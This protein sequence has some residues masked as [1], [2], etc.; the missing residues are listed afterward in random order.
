MQAQ[1]N[2]MLNEEISN[3]NPT[4]DRL[5]RIKQELTVSL[6]QIHNMHD[7]FRALSN[8]SDT[9]TTAHVDQLTRD[10]D[11]LCDH[12][13]SALNHLSARPK[14]L[15]GKSARNSG[16]SLSS[17]SSRF[18]SIASSAHSSSVRSHGSS[19]L[20]QIKK[21]EA[22][23]RLIE[24]Q[25]KLAANTKTM[26]I[27]KQMAELRQQMT[28]VELE[29]QIEAEKQKAAIYSQAMLDE[30]CSNSGLM[31]QPTQIINH[32]ASPVQVQT[33]PLPIAVE[34]VEDPLSDDGISE[35]PLPIPNSTKHSDLLGSLKW[36]TPPKPTSLSSDPY[37]PQATNDLAEAITTAFNMNRLP[38][39]EPKVFDGNP[40][41]YPDWIFSFDNLIG[42]KAVSDHDRLHYLR[43]Y[44][45]GKALEAVEG[46]LLLRS[47]DAYKQARSL[48]D[49]RFGSPF[50]VAE[51]FRTKIE[52]W[53]AI[54]PKDQESLRKFSDFLQQAK[55]A[56]RTIKQLVILDDNRENKK[57][58]SK[59]PEH[60]TRK[61]VRDAT[62]YS[63]KHGTFPT[64]SVF[65]KFLSDET[66]IS[67]NPVFS[68]IFSQKAQYD[69]RQ[70][71]QRPQIPQGKD[72]RTYATQQGVPNNRETK[73][74]HSRCLYCEMNNH[75]TAVCGKINCLPFAEAHVFIRNKRLCY[76]CLDGCH[77]ARDCTNPTVCDTCKGK[78][79]TA[80]HKMKTQNSLT[81]RYT[82]HNHEKT[83][84]QPQLQNNQ[85]EPAQASDNSEQQLIPPR[86]N[87]DE[88]Q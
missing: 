16:S 69:N 42:N 13:E 27:E 12:T 77:S 39:P 63:N 65:C 37:P 5:K 79:P 61:W 4:F 51:S 49:R 46:Y 35:L 78:H 85:A 45:S 88:N 34:Q 75:T 56:Q 11:M 74:D 2:Q 26:A 40:L 82:Q 57:I 9:T 17:K 6:T 1:L 31:L 29:S 73:E 83:V 52:Q 70:Y 23:A 84:E 67:C 25:T 55:T 36:I 3:Q 62:N 44:L 87:Q 66:E 64:F 21:S 10:I 48:L 30:E 81:S 33:D 58:I 53:P 28:T 14:S 19:S 86:T 72:R 38:P 41:H 54:R 60:I 80:L 71:N 18:C 24:L 50:A 68:D 32:A 47:G 76:S 43:R 20:L 8:G 15:S 59:L 7:S 22:A